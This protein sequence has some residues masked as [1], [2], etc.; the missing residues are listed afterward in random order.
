MLLKN[1]NLFKAI[2]FSIIVMLISCREL[3]IN[4]TLK[5][6]ILQISPNEVYPFDV[7]SIYGEN[8]GNYS[9]S[10]FIYLDSVEFKPQIIK[11][12]NN[13]IQFIAPKGI[14]S[15]NLFLIYPNNDT[16]NTLRLYAFPYPKIDFAE[17]P[18]GSFMMGSETGLAYEKPVHLVDI[19]YSF[20]ISKHEIT[21]KQWLTL[22]DTNPSPFVGFDLPVSNIS[23]VEAIH[24]CNK[25][26]K[27]LGFDTCYSFRNGK[28]EWDTSANG[29]RLPTE[30]EW[31]YSC[32]AGTSGDFAGT[33]NPLDMGWYDINSGAKPHPVGTKFANQWGI[34]D[35]H[36]N[37][38]EWCWDW[39]D[40]FYYSKSSSTN[41]LG[42]EDGTNKVVRGGS[43]QLGTT[44]ARSSSRRFPEEQKSNFGF[45]IVRKI[46][47]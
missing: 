41:P 26:S 18:A 43:W 16:T 13:F 8:L 20:L 9:D 32:R 7:V 30:A 28:V 36:G 22:M 42:P 19:T 11:W 1:Y 4:Y 35:M 31:E 5:P 12:N 40:P 39:F 24:F 23:W 38:W 2:V 46:K 47:D 10:V 29:F 33:G 37:V 6:K 45:R 44:F 27:M 34:F 17:V 25:L 15:G 3:S 21:Q 14:K